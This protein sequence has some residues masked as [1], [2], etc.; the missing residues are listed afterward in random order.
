MDEHAVLATI[1]RRPR[2]HAIQLYAPRDTS[3][4]KARLATA[5]ASPWDNCRAR[6]WMEAKSSAH[7]ASMFHQTFRHKKL[8]DTSQGGSDMDPDP[9]IDQF[10]TT[11]TQKND[12]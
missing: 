9:E 11:H 12:H 3:E 5:M 2:A 10:E 8:V 6:A 1:S 4:L 7:C